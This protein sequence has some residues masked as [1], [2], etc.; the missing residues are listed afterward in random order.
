MKQL[1]TRTPFSMVAPLAIY[2]STPTRCIKCFM[3]MLAIVI[4]TAHAA[5]AT[6]ETPVNLELVNAACTIRNDNA[7]FAFPTA[8][9]SKVQF[10]HWVIANHLI[11]AT[12]AGAPW[13][14]SNEQKWIQT[15][16]VTCKTANSVIT[17]FRI[18]PTSAANQYA[19][20]L[21][22]QH[23]VDSQG[24]KAFGAEGRISAEMLEINGNAA[25]STHFKGQATPYTTPFFTS[26]A[27][28]TT[29]ESTATIKWRPI[30]Y[31]P[32]ANEVGTPSNQERF[33]ASF[34]LT[35]HY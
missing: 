5:V 30:I 26:A 4:S 12:Q 27:E 11:Y 34:T 6:M 9:S 3:A 16:T 22:E 7:E 15:A 28:P 35:I 2:P 20:Q 17:S 25:A 32:D 1:S 24:V 21:G 13:R 8:T 33:T 31:A 10:A 23:L 14:T 29:G 18:S 19:G